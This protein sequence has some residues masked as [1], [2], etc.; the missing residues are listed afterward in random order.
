MSQWGHDFRPEYMQL[1]LLHERFPGVPR[2]ALTATADSVDARGD[3]RAPRPGRARA[4]SSPASTGPTS[5]TASSRRPM[6]ARS[7][8]PSCAPSIAGEAGIVYCLSRRKVEE[9]AAWLAE[10]G[11]AA[12]ALPRRHGRR[13]RAAAPGAVSARRRHRHGGHHRLR[14][15][16]RQARRALRRASRS[17][18]EHRGLLPGDRPRRPRRPAGRRLDGLRPGRRGQPAAHDRCLDG[19]R[20]NSSASPRPSSTPCSACAKPPLAAACA[21]WPISAKPRRPAA[22]A[23]S[24]SSRRRSGT[25]P[26]R[27]RRRC[28]ASIAPAS[29]SARCT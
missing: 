9:T 11:V 27:R 18:Q 3:H 4:C 24:A 2:I 21:C 8:S 22:T 14:H 10:Q 29:A 17:A 23:T 13:Q 15:G 25:A 6:P 12:L 5:A 28:P 19:R 7:C 1:S 20:R 16:H 26:S